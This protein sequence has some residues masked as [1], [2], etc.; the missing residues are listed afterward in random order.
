MM[1]ITLCAVQMDRKMS[2]APAVVAAPNPRIGDA[3]VQA[4]FSEKC[5]FYFFVFISFMKEDSSDWIHI[6]RVYWL[7]AINSL[8]Y[9]LAFASCHPGPV[10]PPAKCQM[11]GGK[12]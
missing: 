10:E 9:K 11:L 8:W 4:Q 7:L 12:K 6:H 5:F 2:P 3:W 1:E